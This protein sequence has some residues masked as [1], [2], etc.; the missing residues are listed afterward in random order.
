VFSISL[1]S[2]GNQVDIREENPDKVDIQKFDLDK[3]TQKHIKILCTSI[4]FNYYTFD[5]IF[6][7]KEFWLVDIIPNG[8]W[9]AFD[10]NKALD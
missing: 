3:K 7:G 10:K 4:G 1:H 2:S 9:Y 5:F 8:S 6:D